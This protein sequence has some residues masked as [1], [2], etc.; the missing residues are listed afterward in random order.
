MKNTMKIKSIQQTA[1]ALLALVFSLGSASAAIVSIPDW[2]GTAGQSQTDGGSVVSA[3][4]TVYYLSGKMDFTTVSSDITDYAFI[5]FSSGGTVR[6]LLGINSTGN[7]FIL[8][9]YTGGPTNHNLNGLADDLIS[10]DSVDFV[11]KVD[12]VNSS[13]SFWLNPDRTKLEN[14]QG[15]ATITNN[16]SPFTFGSLNIITLSTGGNTTTGNTAFS[17]FAFYTDTDSPFAVPEPSTYA[18][19]FGGLALGFVMLRRR[20]KV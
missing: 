9:T 11:L 8:R 5:N 12:Q 10:G 4:N 6:F 1:I 15:S 19:I 14:D 20:F 2:T 17:N 3:D 18:L 13:M 16:L 7:K